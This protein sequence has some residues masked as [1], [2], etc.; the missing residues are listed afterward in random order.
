MG[1]RAYGIN[2]VAQNGLQQ[3]RRYDFRVPS[4]RDIILELA[5]IASAGHRHNS[6]LRMPHG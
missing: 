4:E 5:E 6:M 1:G 3:H 2:V